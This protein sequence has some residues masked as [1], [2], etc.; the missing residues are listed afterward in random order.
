MTQTIQA[1]P[2]TETVRQAAPEDVARWLDEGDA[3]LIDVREDFE[4]AEASIDGAVHTPLSAIDPE[5]IR[6][7]H[8]GQRLVFHCKAGRVAEAGEPVYC[9]AGGIDA[10]RAAGLPIKR[11]AH[12]PRLP[13]MRQ[14]QIVAGSLVVIGVALGLLVTAWFLALSAFVGCGLVFAGATG[15]CGMARLLGVM[16]WNRPPKARSN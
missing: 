2:H 12:A 6:R 11:S 3:V 5:G 14:V 4:H 7:A 16:P 9:L 10:W 1:S 13:V 8:A 15:W